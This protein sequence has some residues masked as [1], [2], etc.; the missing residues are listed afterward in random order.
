MAAGSLRGLRQRQ[1]GA[2]PFLPRRTRHG[3]ARPFPRPAG[4]GHRQ[5]RRLSLAARRIHPD[6][7]DR[8][9][10]RALQDAGHRREREGGVHQHGDGV[11]L[12]RRR[13]AG[14]VLSDR[15]PGRCRRAGAQARARRDPAAQFHP[16][17]GDAVYVGDTDHLR[18]RRVRAGHGF[19]HGE[20]R[21][22]RLQGEARRGQEARETARHRHGDLH[23]A[24][25][26]RLSG[27]RLDRVQGPPHRA[28]DGQR[29]IRH[30]ARHLLQAAGRGSPGRRSRQDRRDHGRHRPHAAR[31]HRRLARAPRGRHRAARSLE[32]NR[33]EGPAGGRQSAGGLT[34]RHR[35]RRG[36][37]SHRRHR[38]ARRS[39]HGRGG[40][41][42]SIEAAARHGAGARR[43]SY[44]DAHRRNVSQ[45]LPHRRG[46]DRSRYRRREDRALHRRRRFRRGDQSAAA[47]GPGPWW[48]GAG[49][50]PSLVRAHGL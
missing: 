10:H 38:P 42:R 9:G 37:V 6:A 23:R 30:R 41:A 28:R 46:R 2:R 7:L 13:T 15:A 49:D 25:R 26:R 36:R 33:R 17:R 19:G 12:S 22:G 39:V 4:L 47:R 44:K 45:R 31:A 35:I 1:P 32:G 5:S 8:S 43:H 18:F 24:L 34:R 3:P 48:G 20:G 27:D 40:G 50:R 16:A 11:R 21:L 29:R 14:G